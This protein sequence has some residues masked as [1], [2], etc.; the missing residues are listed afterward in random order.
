MHAAH[1]EILEHAVK[2]GAVRL[3]DGPQVEA[4]HVR[5]ILLLVVRRH[6]RQEVEVICVQQEQED[7]QTIMC[8]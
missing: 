1:P 8:C 7:S 5:Q 6:L 2:D 3:A 4:P